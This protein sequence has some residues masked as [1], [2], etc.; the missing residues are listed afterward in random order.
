M[1]APDIDVI[2]IDFE[3]RPFGRS[4]GNPIEVICMVAYRPSTDEYFRLWRDA[5][6]A[7]KLPPFPIGPE[8]TLVAYYAS[9][10]IACFQALS[11]PLPARILDLYAEFRNLSNGLP[12]I[13][14]RSLL[15]ALRFFGQPAIEGDHKEAMRQLALRGG[16]YSSSEQSA[17]LEYCQSDVDGLALLL[18]AMA[19]Q[20]DY[21]R[22]ILRGTYCIP[23]SMMESYGCPI[24]DGLYA[25]LVK[26]WEQIKAGLIQR[27]DASYGVYEGGAF[28]ESRFEGYLSRAGIDRWPRHPTG[29]LKVDEN[30]FKEMAQTHPQIRP[31]RQ[32]RD[33]LSKLRLNALQV[34]FDGRNRCLL[35][36]YSSVTGRNQPSTNKF[37]FGLARWARGLIQ[38]KPGFAIAYIDWS[39][40][41]FGI[42]AAL[43]GDTNMQAAYQSGDPY[44]EFAKQAGAVPLD[45]TKNSHPNER[46][47]YKQCVLATQYGMGAESLAAKLGQPTLRAKQ[48]L[49]MHRKVYRQFWAWSDAVYN[50]TVSQNRIQTVYG[51][52]TH[53]IADPNPRSLRNFPMQAN[54]AD[55]LRIAC[56][57][58]AE[59]GVRLC[60]PV[61]DAVLIEAPDD[62]IEVQVEIAKAC[63]EEASKL[64]LAGFALSSDAD[65]IRYPN[66]FLDDDSSDFWNEVMS[67]LADIKAGNV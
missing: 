52:Q 21:P 4:E 44:L 55:M 6:Y 43:S 63:M 9:A 48:L 24:D 23:L 12:L 41:E 14:G 49:E 8:V 66:R 45:A 27:I 67:S 38:P 58:M 47:Q 16:D 36:A 54:A 1:I 34:G 5:L 30:T 11:W 33:S 32:L 19:K 28:K 42:A 65:I 20:I 60:A 18:D 7:L 50:Q 17:L 39:Q 35:S 26:H 53:V 22:A 40:Q 57:L 25:D 2:C 46:N 64:V 31:L 61:H 13:H 10:E 29:R 15:G 56:I 59:R 51:W 62:E 37:V 3:F